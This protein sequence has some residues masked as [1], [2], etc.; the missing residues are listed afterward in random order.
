MYRSKDKE[1]MDGIK[2]SALKVTRGQDRDDRKFAVDYMRTSIKIEDLHASA[3]Q[4]F[5]GKIIDFGSGSLAPTV[6]VVTKDPI[7][8]AE[9]ERLIGVFKK[10][11][12][13]NEVFFTHLRFVKTKKK[14]D[15][16]LDIFQKL[17]N[18]LAPKTVLIFD[19]VKVEVKPDVL[20]T[21][22]DVSVLTDPD[23]RS[24]RKALNVIFKKIVRKDT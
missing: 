23:K 11:Q 18:I 16:R 12:I 2:E 3:V 22:E 4:Q 20:K 21:G 24:E 6:V 5:P 8:R 1:Y 10:M 15:E 9:K 17:I 14:Q 19:K 7:G 13:E